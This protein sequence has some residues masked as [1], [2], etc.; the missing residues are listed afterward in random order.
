MRTD[1]QIPSGQQRSDGARDKSSVRIIVRS[2]HRAKSD[3]LARREGLSRANT[4]TA[5]RRRLGST[6]LGAEFA[7]MPVWT[8][9]PDIVSVHDFLHLG[10]EGGTS[11]AAA[12]ARP[13]SSSAPTALLAP[14]LRSVRPT[15]GGI[16]TSVSCDDP[17]ASARE[18]APRA[19]L[20]FFRSH[21]RRRVPGAVDEV[22]AGA[23]AAFSSE[24][25]IVHR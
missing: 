3:P 4:S 17:A 7:G 20:N 10:Q 12:R 6:T 13:I 24:R 8:N 22:A 15:P 19:A 2:P 23:G 9:R 25:R 21:L 11:P 16:P 5:A 14:P 1:R 18:R